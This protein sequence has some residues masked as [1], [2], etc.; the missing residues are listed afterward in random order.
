MGELD[1]LE[2]E[3]RIASTIVEW[4]SGDIWGHVG[5]R[6]PESDSIAVKFFRPPEEPGV[7]DWIIHFDYDLNKVSGV[8]IIPIEATIYTEIFKARPDVRAIVHS[9]PP[10]CIALSLVDKQ[11]YSIH[12]Q[13]RRFGNG[14]PIYD[15]PIFII[16]SEEGADMARAMGPAPGIVLK[17]HGIVSVGRSID[18]ACITALYMERTAKIQAIAHTLGY[19]APTKQFVQT[20]ED[21]YTKLMARIRELGR[22]PHEHSAEWDYYADKVRKGE[23]WPRGW[24]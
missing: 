15:P 9:H 11:L 17:G 24:T 4:E 16:D 5:V 13:S 6:V 14:L 20:I 2:E 3:L 23:Q 8:G 18:E 12:Q 19:S 7:K 21:T 10:M 22:P 1:V